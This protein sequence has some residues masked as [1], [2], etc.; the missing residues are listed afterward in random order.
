MKTYKTTIGEMEIYVTGPNPEN[1]LVKSLLRNVEEVDTP[2]FVER[3]LDILKG[4]AQGIKIDPHIL[5]KLKGFSAVNGSDIKGLE[6]PYVW[7]DVEG[8]KIGLTSSDG[9]RA[10][11]VQREEWTL[12]RYS[13]EKTFPFPPLWKI[14]RRKVHYTLYPDVDGRP[15]ILIDTYPWKTVVWWNTPDTFT[16]P[17]FDAVYMVT[18]GRKVTFGV[19][20]EWGHLNL[21]LHDDEVS[22]VGVMDGIVGGERVVVGAGSNIKGPVSVRGNLSLIFPENLRFVKVAI[23][24]HFCEDR[25][26]GWYIFKR[27][28]D[29]E[30]YYIFPAVY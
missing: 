24:K 2:E 27:Y 4:H 8:G 18:L 13:V 28:V 21:E 29:G 22:T 15:F 20:E 6:F 23:F 25:Q 26:T 5:S 7:R 11:L 12:D 1:F 14:I 16:P 3:A 9:Y 19:Y 17:N 30:E 10:F